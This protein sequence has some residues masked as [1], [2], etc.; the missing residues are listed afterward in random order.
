MIERKLTTISFR[1]TKEQSVAIDAIS[2]KLNVNRQKIV[3]S[4]L[5]KFMLELSLMPAK[6][7]ADLVRYF[8]HQLRAQKI[9]EGA[10]R[11]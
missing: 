6:D 3:R 1:P 2:K 11:D 9:H 4:A 10:Y 7:A 8:D 5:D